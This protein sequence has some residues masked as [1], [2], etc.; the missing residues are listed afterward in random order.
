LAESQTAD[1]LRKKVDLSGVVQQSLWEGGRTLAAKG[2]DDS[3]NI[4]RLLRRILCNNLRD[5][6]RRVTAAKRDVRLEQSIETSSI[7][8]GG[9]LRGD[10]PSPS[11]NA[12]LNERAVMVAEAI[13]QLSDDQRSVIVRHYLGGESVETTAL[14]MSRSIPSVAGLLHRALKNL[15]T[16]LGDLDFGGEQ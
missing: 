4:P 1:A 8:L 2:C 10:D 9:L 6:I 12:I 5:E 11:Q 14:A 7:R 13:M 16:I 15:R 3:A